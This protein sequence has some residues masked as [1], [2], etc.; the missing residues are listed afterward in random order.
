MMRDLEIK[1]YA[2]QLNELYMFS[3]KKRMLKGG[4]IVVSQKFSQESTWV[5]QDPVGE[6]FT[7]G[8]TNMK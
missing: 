4:I 3:Q 6:M 5:G 1:S 7:E 8:D 2:E